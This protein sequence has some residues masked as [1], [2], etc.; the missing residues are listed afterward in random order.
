MILTT[1]GKRKPKRGKFNPDFFIKTSFLILVIEI[2]D[3]DEISEPSTENKK[4]NEY[5]LIHFEKINTYLQKNKK[6]LFYK[7]NFLTPVDFNGYFQSIREGKVA[8]YRSSLD[9]EL[10]K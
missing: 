5:A 7:F 1:S 10:K 3:D 6:N 2:K 4:K 8:N 9:V